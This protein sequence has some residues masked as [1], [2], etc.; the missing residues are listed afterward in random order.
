MCVGIAGALPL[1]TGCDGRPLAET[2]TAAQVQPISVEVNQSRDQY[3][4]Q[5]VQILLTNTTATPLTVSGTRLDTP[6]FDGAI[7]WDPTD[8]GLVLPPQQPKSVAAQLPAAAC[9]ASGSAA[10]PLKA[11]VNYAEPGEEAHEAVVDATDP[12]GVL[13]RN[14]GELCLAA[15]AAGVAHF[16][17]DPGLDVAPDGRTAVVRLVIQ[18]AATVGPHQEMALHNIEET[19]LLAESPTDPWPRDLTVMAGTAKQEIALGIRPARCDPHAVA[20]D[21][22]GT[23]L[24]LRV[25]VGEREGQVKIAASEQLR[26]RMYDFVTTACAGQ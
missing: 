19:T 3:G 20:E 17:L 13:T 21:K 14:A 16:A 7:A 8:G 1:A 24:P 11:A 2:S 25:R 15:E 5:A 9:G 12:Y 22:V 26:G 6:L 10:E 4:K 23:L 18:P